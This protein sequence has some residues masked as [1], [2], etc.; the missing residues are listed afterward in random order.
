MDSFNHPDRQENQSGY[1]R[2]TIERARTELP[3]T[4]ETS[5]G[6]RHVTLTDISV[7]GAMIEASNLPRAGKSVVIN[8]GVLTVNAVVIWEREGRSGLAF[9]DPADGEA[10]V[11]LLRS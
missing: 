11:A 5:A 9:T 4:V 1:E 7:L 6:L 8:C 2:R 3:A 10:V